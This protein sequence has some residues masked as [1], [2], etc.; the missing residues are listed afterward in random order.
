MIEEGTAAYNAWQETP[1]PVFTKFYF[2]DLVSPQQ[3]LFQKEKP[4]LYQKGPYTFREVEK[5][6]NISWNSDNTVTYR[7]MKFWFFERDMSVGPL[8][9][10]VTTINV[11]MVGAAEFAR[12]DFLMEWG[13]SDMLAS[14]QVLRRNLH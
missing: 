7:R 3:L 13:V 1:V 8:T 10:T 5:K 4:A 6:V 11:P 2:F 14:M 9:D 12:G